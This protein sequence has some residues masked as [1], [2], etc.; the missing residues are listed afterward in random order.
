MRTKETGRIGLD[1]R[2]NQ[3]QVASTEGKAFFLV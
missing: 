2:E 1:S 3:K